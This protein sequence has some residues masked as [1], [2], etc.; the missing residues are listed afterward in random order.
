MFLF[1]FLLLSIT[2]S[3]YRSLDHLQRPRKLFKN[4]R[5]FVNTFSQA[6]PDTIKL[7]LTKIEDLLQEGKD[8]L[9]SAH[10]NHQDKLTAFNELEQSLKLRGQENQTATVNL[11]SSE[12]LLTQKLDELSVQRTKVTEAATEEKTLKG[13]WETQKTL[14][15]LIQAKTTEEAKDFEELLVLFKSLEPSQQGHGRRLL[16]TGEGD[17]DRMVNFVI[18]M[19]N[20]AKKEAS[21]AATSEKTARTQ[22]DTAKKTLDQET[23]TKIKLEEEERL[24]QEKVTQ[25]KLLLD[26]AIN[27]LKVITDSHAKG[28]EEL[29]SAEE[30]LNNEITRVTADEETLNQVKEL[31]KNLIS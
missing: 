16:E 29:E 23:L 12:K 1:L 7:L 17:V 8:D 30:F 13:R 26:N 31:L 15:D 20:A 24:L 6:N 22:Y 14:S 9:S 3:S 18:E 27:S 2:A 25:N 10:D 11:A 5:K 28:K 4:P 21:D 19:Q